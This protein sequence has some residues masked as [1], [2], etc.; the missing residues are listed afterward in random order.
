MWHHYSI[1]VLPQR[2]VCFLSFGELG[3]FCVKQRLYLGKNDILMPFFALFIYFFFNRG[4]I[5]VEPNDFFFP[6]SACE[7]RKMTRLRNTLHWCNHAGIC[8]WRL[9]RFYI[10]NEWGEEGGGDNNNRFEQ[11]K[12]QKWQKQTKKNGLISLLMCMP[13][14]PSAQCI[15]ALCFL[16][17]RPFIRWKRDGLHMNV[18]RV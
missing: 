2:C 8:L 1:L 12:E 6:D 15:A 7:I 9:L 16:R 3:V 10:L 4:T 11:K 14:S 18:D 5:G 13:S 17:V